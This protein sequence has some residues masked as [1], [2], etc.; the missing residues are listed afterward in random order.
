[1][2]VE[3]GLPTLGEV[4][5]RI[6]RREVSPVEVTEEVLARIARFE[7]Q[8]NAFI[9]VMGESALDAARVAEA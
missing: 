9:T 6:A 4:A 2:L 7:P 8:L 1:M 3:P 5:G